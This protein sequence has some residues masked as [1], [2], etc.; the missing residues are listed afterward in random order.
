MDYL[1]SIQFRD[2]LYKQWKLINPESQEYLRAKL[3]LKVLNE[4]LSRNIR[5]AKKDYYFKQF[6]KYRWDIRKT[7]DTLKNILNK[8]KSK[9]VHLKMFLIDGHQV[10]NMTSIANKF[11][12]YFIFVGFNLANAT[13]TRGKSAYT[14]YLRAPSIT[15]FNFTYTNS[16][17]VRI[18]INNLKPKQSAGHDYISLKLLKDIGYI[19]A[20]TLS[21]IINQSLYTGNFSKQLK[22]AKV[23]PLFTK[24][25]ETSIENY[26]PI[27]L[28]SVMKNSTLTV[29]N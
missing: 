8:L 18:L 12:E 14:S 10:T 6:E 27:S 26:R 17:E 13:D 2:N 15:T 22:I 5:L 9:Y 21:V 7:W 16:D 29:S 4:I 24:G 19:I 11:N 20:P 25:E 1:K 28:L 3:N 23:N